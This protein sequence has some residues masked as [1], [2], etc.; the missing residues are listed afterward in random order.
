MSFVGRGAV[1]VLGRVRPTEP[2][3]IEGSP[4]GL[5]PLYARVDSGEVLVSGRASDLVRPDAR[6]D[7]DRLCA[8]LV[9]SA[10]LKA[11][12]S[13]FEGVIQIAPDTTT[14]IY[15]DRIHVEPHQ[16]AIEQQ[17][18]APIEAADELWRRVVAS[19]KSATADAK[20]VAVAT[21]GG[22]DSS[23]I[24]AA[25]LAVC[26]GAN[27]KDAT[28]VALHFSG[29][30]D[31]RPYLRDLERELGIVA[32]KVSPAEGGSSLLQLLT[33]PTMPGWSWSAAGDLSIFRA[34]RACGA[35]LVLTGLGGDDLLDGLP[36]ALGEEL[37]RGHFDAL[38]RAARLGPS[39]ASSLRRISKWV[40]RPIV[41]SVLP[42]R[43]LSARRRRALSEERPWLGAA[44]RRFLAE[45]ERTW[46]PTR[47]DTPVARFDQLA[48]ATYLADAVET[49]DESA[50]YADIRLAHPFL[51]TSIVAFVASL[52]ATLLLHGDR[53]RGLFRLAIR[54]AVPGHV[55]LRSTKADF[56]NAWR[57]TLNAAGGIEILR[58]LSTMKECARIGL[59]DPDVFR[60]EFSELERD[61]T[62]WTL[63]WPLLGIEGFLRARPNRA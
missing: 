60:A 2:V 51:D 43:F 8:L 46:R 31:D 4:F 52:P 22:V 16:R 9:S 12:A 29:E 7:V 34:A 62:I 38:I 63:L 37:T 6:V 44:F 13:L 56:L 24:F 3:R 42:N 27:R 15:S 30:G 57:E 25:A 18:I 47:F 40:L 45:Q 14:N 48:K 23:G 1:R 21:G 33:S 39:E 5:S 10:P 53:L 61:S 17:S 28:A 36:R 19:V 32:I 11:G 35:D 58:D 20:H 26:R 59:V 55:R 41:A 54:G 49:A 50:S